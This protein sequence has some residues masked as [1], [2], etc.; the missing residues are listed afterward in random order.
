MKQPNFAPPGRHRIGR[1][2]L[3]DR[4]KCVLPS[5]RFGELESD[6]IPIE[7]GVRKGCVL[8]PDL[9]N[10]YSECI[11]RSCEEAG[12][13]FGGRNITNIRYA[14]DAFDDDQRRRPPNIAQPYYHRKQEVLHGTEREKQ[15]SWLLRRRK[16]IYRIL[17]GYTRLEKVQKFL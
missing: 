3:Q 7:K 10:S 5:V 12:V 13:E 9:Y 6:T 15:K 2:E 1:Q 4:T 16:K 8:S 17:A 14:E 11:M